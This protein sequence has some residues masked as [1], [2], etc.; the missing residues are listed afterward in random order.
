MSR[1]ATIAWIA[2][3]TSGDQLGGWLMQALREQNNALRFIG[4]GGP[5]MEEQGLQSLFPIR[6]I[7]LIGIAEILPHVFTIKRRIRETV[8]MIERE[9]PDMVV[10]IDSPGFVLRVIKQLRARGKV[11]PKFVHY[12]APTV[13]AYRPKRAELMA[14]RFDF[15]LCLLPFEPPYFDAVRLPN[16]FIGHEVAW[17]WKSRGDGAAFRHTHAI[18]ASAPL[19]AVFPGSRQGEITRLWP[20]FKEAIERL[21]ADI[22]ELRVVIQVPAS[23][24]PR[25]QSETHGWDIAP[26]ILTNTEDKK[27]LFAAATAA[28]AK[29]GTI[30]LECAL[31]GLPSIVAYRA[32]A[33]T[34]YMLRRMIKIPYANLANLLA[35]RPIIPELLQEDCTG[36]KIAVTMRP[37]LTNAQARTAQCDAIADIAAMLG[38][39][40]TES[41]SQKAAAIILT[42]LN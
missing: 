1:P 12:V 28:I 20:A 22:P 32:S 26:L 33:L 14:E 6:D 16:R 34:A 5:R 3:E 8:A 37:L 36:E 13:W 21:K 11:R 41:P 30:G 39:R 19:L 35:N 31:A 15:L 42:M 2:G 40:D 18:P 17:W 23:V 7:A 24:L 29:S 10:S 38:T 27:G 25:M 4:V 9:N